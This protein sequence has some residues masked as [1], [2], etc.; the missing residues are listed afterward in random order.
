MVLVAHFNLELYQI[1][2]KIIFLNWD[3]EKEVYMCQPESLYSEKDNYLVCKLRKSINT[4]GMT[5]VRNVIVRKIETL[6]LWFLISSP[7]A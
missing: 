7:L 3:L 2:V 4:R 5:G 1:D 6:S